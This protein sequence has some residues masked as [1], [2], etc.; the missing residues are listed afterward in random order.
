MPPECSAAILKTRNGQIAA[1]AADVALVVLVVVLVPAA[2]GP[3][4][5][6]AAGLASGFHEREGVGSDDGLI[7][8]QHPGVEGRVGSVWWSRRG[9]ADIEP[10]LAARARPPRG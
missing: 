5:G 7:V 10:R 8:H 6:D 9:I 2:A 4:W 1:A 3:L